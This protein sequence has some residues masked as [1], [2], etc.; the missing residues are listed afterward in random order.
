MKVH[1]KNLIILMII[2]I[3]VLFTTSLVN[4]NLSAKKIKEHEIKKLNSD[5]LIYKK[6]VD[7]FY[8]GL[9]KYSSFLEKSY[10]IENFDLFIKSIKNLITSDE[11]IKS[12]ELYLIENKKM[13][14]IGK[15]SEYIDTKWIKLMDGIKNEKIVS[16]EGKIYYLNRLKSKNKDFAY[17]AFEIDK[18]KFYENF[19]MNESYFI[20]DQRET[21]VSEES[22]EKNIL[23]KF[24][25]MSRSSNN[26]YEYNEKNRYVYYSYLKELDWVI[27]MK[28]VYSSAEEKFFLI[29]NFSLSSIL[30]III[31][32][33]LGIKSNKENISKPLLD[34]TD[35]L[36]NPEDKGVIKSIEFKE[37]SELNDFVSAFDSYIDDRD[38]V[39]EEIKKSYS[40]IFRKNLLI[41]R[42]FE[43]FMKNS[44]FE[45]KKT[46]NNFLKNIKKTK[47]QLLKFLVKTD[48]S[49]KHLNGDFE[50]VIE[51]IQ[52]SEK[53]INGLSIYYL[54]II[55]LSNDSDKLVEQLENEE[56]SNKEFITKIRQKNKRVRDNYDSFNGELLR[57]NKTIEN[58]KNLIN[59]AKDYKDK[60]DSNTLALIESINNEMKEFN[61]ENLN[62]YEKEIENSDK[63][64]EVLYNNMKKKTDNLK[65]IKHSLNSFMEKLNKM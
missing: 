47:E 34:L 33:L 49:L 31:F 59:K 13:T 38:K 52:I 11:Y 37:K 30:M 63:E 43:E 22:F 46:K 35:F 16:L 61:L 57:V 24:Q 20:L 18:E 50:T 1:N 56:I 41:I 6:Q 44:K 53:K 55:A 40:D 58:L 25:T 64:K 65:Y 45:V 42:D 2:S 60:A 48:K 62:E 17:I 19:F 4:I 36:K 7:S 26:I 29:R 23:F 54:N 14:F 12:G 10:T 9:N 27:G 32:G 3:F 21:F 28:G 5:I 8:K 39:L 51:K 15:P